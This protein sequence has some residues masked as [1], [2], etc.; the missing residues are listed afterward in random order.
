MSHVLDLLCLQNLKAHYDES[1]DSDNDSQ[2][3]AIAEELN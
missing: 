1:E 2:F 3:D